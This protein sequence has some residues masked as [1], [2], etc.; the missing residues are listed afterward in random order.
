MLGISRIHLHRVC[1]N[2]S[3]NHEWFESLQVFSR[4]HPLRYHFVEFGMGSQLHVSR[5][6]SVRVNLPR[7]A[8]TWSRPIPHSET[9]ME[10]TRGRIDS[11]TSVA[12][13]GFRDISFLECWEIASPVKRL[14]LC[15]M[16]RWILK[17]FLACWCYLRG[18]SSSRRSMLGL[19]WKR[20]ILD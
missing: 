10:T 8:R 16:R 18:L 13:F 20:S 1:H 12:F 3:S 15:V 11:G 14:F 2:Q 4:E 9:T 17:S 19:R 6:Y 5:I 7:W